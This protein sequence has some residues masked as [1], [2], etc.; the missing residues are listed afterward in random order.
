MIDDT[1]PQERGGRLRDRAELNQV[2]HR[3]PLD[4]ELTYRQARPL[5]GQRRDDGVDARTVVQASIDKRLALVDPPPDLGHDPLDDRLSYFLRDKPS[6][7]LLDNALILD[8]NLIALDDHDFA[9]CRR[10]QQVLKRPKAEN[11]I[12]QVL[13]EHPQD[14]VLA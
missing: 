12:L 11:N 13:L 7:R 10:S 14:Q 6:P 4:R 1:G 8:V 2:I 5:D 9:D 3:Q